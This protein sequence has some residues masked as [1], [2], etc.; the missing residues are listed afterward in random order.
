MVHTSGCLYLMFLHYNKNYVKI[1]LL[2]FF[3]ILSDSG[4]IQIN[5][6]GLIS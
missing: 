6:F 2:P 1:S 3:S 4:E 5:D